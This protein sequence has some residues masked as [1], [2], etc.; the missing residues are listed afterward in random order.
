[1]GILDYLGYGDAGPPEPDP[2]EMQSP[3]KTGEGR[4]GRPRKPGESFPEYFRSTR[5]RRP[6]EDVLP[7]PEWLYQMMGAPPPQGQQPIFRP[8][9]LRETYDMLNPWSKQQAPP[10]EQSPRPG[11]VSFNPGLREGTNYPRPTPYRNEEPRLPPMAPPP[12]G[13]GQLPPGWQNPQDRASIER[14]RMQEMEMLSEMLRRGQVPGGPPPPGARPLP[15]PPGGEIPGRLW[16]E[17]RRKR[18]Q[19]I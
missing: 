17:R 2:A 19:M 10:P 13:V 11:P 5:S 3:T 9:S 1:M 8:H 15:R 6:Y 14:R 4:W 12:L 18:G 7:V 16:E